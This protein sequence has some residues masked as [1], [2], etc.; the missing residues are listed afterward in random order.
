VEENAVPSA[1][2]AIVS[3]PVR[4]SARPRVGA[5]QHYDPR[6]DF[7]GDAPGVQEK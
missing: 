7:I 3:D 1:T 4:D 6:L 2:A 5:R